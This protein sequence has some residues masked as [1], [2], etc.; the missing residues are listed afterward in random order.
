MLDRISLRPP[1]KAPAPRWFI[2]SFGTTRPPRYRLTLTGAH[3]MTGFVLICI[4]PKSPLFEA[5]GL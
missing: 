3:L 1:R 2:W 4:I 5:S